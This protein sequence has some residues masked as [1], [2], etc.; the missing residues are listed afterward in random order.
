MG[1]KMDKKVYLHAV[2]PNY[3]DF[4][5]DNKYYEIFESILKDGSI[6]SPRLRGIGTNNDFCGPDFISLCDYEKRDIGFPDKHGIYNGFNSYCINDPCIVFPK[7]VFEV[8]ETVTLPKRIDKYPDYK[9]FLKECGESSIR[10]SDLCDEVQAMDRIL[11][12]DMVGVTLPLLSYSNFWLNDKKNAERI[13]SRLIRYLE[14]LNK[15]GYSVP[16]YDVISG[17]EINDINSI[18]NVVQGLRE[19]YSIFRLTKKR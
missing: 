5:K 1:V 11:L 14:L 19:K 3:F 16:F 4:Y 17:E 13:Y 15:Y 6:L 12:S 2:H 8:Y 18:V 10:Y 9:S 7:G